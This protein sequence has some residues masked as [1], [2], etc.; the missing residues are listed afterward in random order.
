MQRQLLS[1]RATGQPS[2][3]RPSGKNNCEAI[4]SIL[5]GEVIRS[6]YEAFVPKQAPT[7]H[8]PQQQRTCS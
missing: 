4:E 3:K 7:A 5:P 6:S 8:R 2:P 1:L